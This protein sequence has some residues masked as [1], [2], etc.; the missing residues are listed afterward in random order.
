MIHAEKIRRG[1]RR[2]RVASILAGC[3]FFKFRRLSN[4]LQVYYS[5]VRCENVR[6]KLNKQTSRTLNVITIKLPVYITFL[7][8]F[9]G[10]LR[11]AEIR[12]D[13]FT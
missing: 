7:L 9:D 3:A 8:Q 1:Y 12:I 2:M 6:F 13:G 5:S 4:F 11:K 10:C